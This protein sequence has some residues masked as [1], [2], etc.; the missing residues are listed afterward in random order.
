MCAANVKGYPGYISCDGASGFTTLAGMVCPI[1]GADGAAIG[2]WDLDSTQPLAPEDPVFLDRY[3]ATLSA[4]LRP[5][6][7]REKQRRR[8]GSRGLDGIR[9]A[10]FLKWKGIAE[11][12]GMAKVLIQGGE[13]KVNGEVE[14]RRGRRLRPGDLIQ[15]AGDEL[16]VDS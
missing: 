12:G 1:R 9:L 8:R 5:T 6:H 14:T 15:V 13:V 11:S 3:F 7:L 16:R 4:V 10:Q 2:V